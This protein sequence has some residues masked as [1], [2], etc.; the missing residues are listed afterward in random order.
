MKE[1]TV[2]ITKNVFHESGE[3]PN[4]FSKLDVTVANKHERKIPKG[5]VQE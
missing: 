5:V 3:R 4:A 2:P 1:T